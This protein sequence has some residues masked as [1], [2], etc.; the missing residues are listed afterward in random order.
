MYSQGIEDAHARARREKTF[1]E[2][3]ASEKAE[4]EAKVAEMTTELREME[5]QMLAMQQ[6]ATENAEIA[7]Q[8]KDRSDGFEQQLAEARE[9]TAASERQWKEKLAELEERLENAQAERRKAEGAASRAGSP[10]SVGT[11]GGMPGSPVAMPSPTAG[12]RA[13]IT[14]RGGGST[15]SGGPSHSEL[16]A[17]TAQQEAALDTL[18]RQVAELE[19]ELAAAHSAAHTASARAD[20]AEAD[21]AAAQRQ[22][23]SLQN[24][25]HEADA[26]AASAA[27]KAADEAAAEH[28]ES[29]AAAAA[30]AA[31]MAR[32]QDSLAEMT[33]KCRA[34]EEGSRKTIAESEAREAQV[35]QL[36]A[37]LESMQGRLRTA[38]GEV[39]DAKDAA[40]LARAE[41]S[42]VQS[43]AAAAKRE[44]DAAL[45][46][47]R[48]Q[49]AAAKAGQ[50]GSHEHN[51]GGAHDD[52]SAAALAAARSE[53]AE[54]TKLVQ[55]WEEYA[56][57]WEGRGR[58][59]E[60][61]L[62][63]YER[64]LTEAEG[65]RSKA[66]TQVRALQ[67][68]LVALR[69]AGSG[70]GARRGSPPSQ[71][72]GQAGGAHIASGLAPSGG[73]YYGN[74]GS[75]TRGRRMSAGEIHGGGGA[76]GPPSL[77]ATES[78]LNMV[79]G[80]SA[81]ASS[82]DSDGPSATEILHRIRA[83]APST[84]GASAVAQAGANPG[85]VYQ[86]GYGGYRGYG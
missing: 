35:A 44:S 74:S 41:L 10:R 62:A 71:H 21:A 72:T 16:L 31:E 19:A 15:P 80:S 26:V 49:L 8:W 17:R 53:I 5:S 81:R 3:L 4:A 29:R 70:G 34:A 30:A 51:R 78:H 73:A 57:H 61:A 13:G 45:A 14:P 36:Q 77:A 50:G 12:G 47:L 69:S 40:A 23:E 20:K 58:E 60:A 79:L 37:Q 2:A 84:A 48:E 27:R 67:E 22:V 68:Q 86:G 25:V 6:S 9:A 42:E 75:P 63:E 59:A 46:S 55:E 33:R 66:E 39:H 28:R 38:A 52:G 43:A 1:R 54:K 76:G 83:S 11:G 32:L 65:G 56:N 85:G 18:E 82:T 24:K 64:K 7:G